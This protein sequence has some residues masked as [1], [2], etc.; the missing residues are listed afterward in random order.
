[1]TLAAKPH[2][3]PAKLT[4]DVTNMDVADVLHAN[5]VALPP[6][7]RR[8]DAGN[9]AIVTVLRTRGTVDEEDAAAEA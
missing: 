7:T 5:D 6:N 3:L 8:V 2:D 9:F 4:I 1:M